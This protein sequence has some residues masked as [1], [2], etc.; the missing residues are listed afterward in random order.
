MKKLFILSVY[1][2]GVMTADV[3]WVRVIGSSDSPVCPKVEVI[4][5]DSSSVCVRTTIFGFTS[6]DTTVDNKDFKHIAIHRELIPYVNSDSDTV[7]VGKPQIPYI[8]ML[9]ALPDSAELDFTISESDYVLYEDYLVFPVPDMVFQ[10]S[11][12]W[13]FYKE[14]YSY[15][16]S[17]YETDTLYPGTLY[18]VHS[19]GH[20]RDQRVVEVFLYPIQFNP[21]HKSMYFY[22]GLDLRISYSGTIVENTQGLGPFEEIGRE[23]LLNYPGIDR[24]P[25]PNPDPGVHFYYNLDTIN[26]ADYIIV[27][28]EDFIADSTD[29]FWIHEFADWRV[30]HNWF[31]VGVVQMNDVYDEFLP[32]GSADSSKALRDFLSYAYNNWNAPIMPDGHFAYCLFVGDWDYV[33]TKILYDNSE[34][35]YWSKEAYFRDLDENLLDDIMLGRWPVKGGEDLSIIAQKTINYECEPDTGDWRRKGLLVAGQELYMFDCFDFCVNESKPF[36][37]DIGY[38]TNTVRFSDTDSEELFID[39]L[40]KYLNQGAIIASYYGHGG[41]HDW[42]SCYDTTYLIAL[43]NDSRLPVVFS[44]SCYSACFQWDYPGNNG[45]TCFGEHFLLSD[46][47]GTVAFYGMTNAGNTQSLYYGFT[48]LNSVLYQQHWIVGKALGASNITTPVQSKKYC[49]LGDPALDLGDYTAFPLLPDLVVRPQGMDISLLPPYPYP[50]CGNS[51]PIQAKVWNIGGATAYDVDIKFEVGDEQ[52]VIYSN[53]LN[54][55]SINP[56]D[57]I[58]LVTYWDTDSTHP[59]YCGEIGELNFSVTADP[60]HEVTESWEYNNNSSRTELVALYPYKAGW[61]K[62]LIVPQCTYPPI[63]AQPQIADLDDS[64]GIEM[65]FPGQDS[66]Y[67][68]NYNGSVFSGWPRYFNGVYSTVLGDVDNDGNIDIIAVSPES[69]I[70]FGYQ[71]DTLTGWPKQVPGAD[72][73]RFYGFPA[74]GYISGSR[75]RQVVL[76][77]GDKGNTPR[78]PRIIVFDYDGD[79]LYNFTASWFTREKYH[80]CGPSIADVNEDRKEEIIVSY[81]YYRKDENGQVVAESSFTDIFNRDGLVR[82]LTWGSAGS[83][84]ALA[85]L[86]GDDVAD[87]I[88]ACVDNSIRAYDENN[89]DTL[90]ITNTAGAINSSPAVGDIYSFYDGVEITVG[91]DNNRIY[92]IR[93]D[94]GQWWFP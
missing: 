62:K 81:E 28:H 17:F 40:D 55:D 63:I 21:K 6:T 12:G 74:L 72:T 43:E 48:V 25:A 86:S 32:Q 10:D 26:I 51:I 39:S 58:L 9:F 73:L 91:N 36:F 7:I 24:Q 33:P 19:D 76:Y 93:G 3:E 56:R 41:Y 92:A 77:A 79:L 80:S 31:E 64:A 23:I 38:D 53:I 44:Q 37:Y 18:Q 68:F 22:H 29:S 42:S 20:W 88:T 83:I 54:V 85:D 59:N 1:F 65:V 49:L 67:I 50:A 57:T 90:W 82:T 70:V 46:S 75:K 69:I 5:S 11:G 13:T 15:D 27:T 4:K 71:G 14:V 60:N 66:I 30:E 87:V 89:R 16:T 84:S 35:W 52:S 2:V 8:R 61:P 47:G 45:C 34:D 94:I 78:K